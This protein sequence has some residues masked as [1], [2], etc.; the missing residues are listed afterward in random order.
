MYLDTD[1]R[2]SPFSFLQRHTRF[3]IL[4]ERAPRASEGPAFSSPCQRARAKDLLFLVLASARERTTRFFLILDYAR[5]RRP[6]LSVANG[7][8][9]VT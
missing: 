9:F 1:S 3:V 8:A 5:E 2:F 6:A 4:S 7:P